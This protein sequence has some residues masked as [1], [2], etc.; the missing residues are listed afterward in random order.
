M[1]RSGSKDNHSGSVLWKDYFAKFCLLILK[2]VRT[3][4]EE[5]LQMCTEQLIRRSIHLT[6]ILSQLKCE[7]D[8]GVVFQFGIT[9]FSGVGGCTYEE[10]EQPLLHPPSYCLKVQLQEK[11]NAA[12][13]TLGIVFTLM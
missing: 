6:G 10:F 12:Y 11:Q 4:G 3:R 9:D 2:V 5:L 1:W 8:W 13:Y 7:V